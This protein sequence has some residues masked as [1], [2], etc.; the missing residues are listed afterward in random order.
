MNLIL[1]ELNDFLRRFKRP[2]HLDNGLA[3]LEMKATATAINKR[4]RSDADYG[5]LVG[6]LEDAFQDV[7]ETFRG[8]G[9]PKTAVFVQ[10]MEN[11]NRRASPSSSLPDTNWSLDPVEINAK[12]MNANEGVGDMW[13]YGRLCV[14]LMRSG[15]VSDATLSAYRKGYFMDLKDSRGDVTEARRIEA[16]MIAKHKAAEVTYGGDAKFAP[17]KYKPKGFNS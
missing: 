17:P 13:I 14:D 16:E 6:I 9:W 8:T 3:L 5:A 15:K 11:I 4:I 2:D 7:S 1:S 12:R 10:S